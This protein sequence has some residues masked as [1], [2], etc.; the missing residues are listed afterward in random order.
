[1]NRYEI[2]IKTCRNQ[3]GESFYVEA[4]S[5]A[6]ALRAAEA[7]AKRTLSATAQRFASFIFC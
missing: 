6:A 2:E 7:H 5:E 1:M 3:P 4:K